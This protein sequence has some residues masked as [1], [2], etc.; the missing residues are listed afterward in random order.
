MEFL[1]ILFHD[2]TFLIVSLGTSLLGFIS[3]LI[4]SFAVLKKQSLLGD[5]VSHAALPGVI[6]VFILTGFKSLPLLLLGALASGLLATFLILLVTRYSKVKF[7][8]ALALF[9]SSFF[10]LGLI[11]LT[12]LQKIPNAQQAG[13]NRFIF[14]QAS[15]ML[16]SDILVIALI[17]FFN[18]IIL[19]L[20]W[21][22]FK[23]ITFDPSYA[24]SLGYPVKG[25][26][27]LLS[28]MMV[29]TIVVGLQSVGVVLMSSLLIAPAVAARQWSD[30]LGVMVFVAGVLGAISGFL[31][32]LISSSFSKIPTGPSIVIVVS[33]FV[34]LSLLFSP[35]RGIILK[36][37]KRRKMRKKQL[38]L[39][40]EVINP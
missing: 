20:F 14:G 30:R 3:G 25:F 35:K 28:L 16:L 36:V 18:L 17:S 32:T 4:G 26:S 5:G 19:F 11:F 6:L 9:L 1:S 34:L 12:Y 7:D 13:L 31:G 29:L 24:Q 23:L 40:E 8:S 2:Y 10:G 33:I 15:T 38:D 22:E 37:I 27:F 21:K 39:M